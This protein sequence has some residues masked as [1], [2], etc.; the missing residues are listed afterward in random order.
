MA[1]KKIKLQVINI[2]GTPDLYITRFCDSFSSSRILNEGETFDKVVE[3]EVA[4]LIENG[5]FDE[6]IKDIEWIGK[7]DALIRFE[8]NEFTVEFSLTTH[9]VT[10]NID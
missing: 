9:Y 6:N 3:E 5:G 2:L 10:I 7:T 1:L 4:S 8:E